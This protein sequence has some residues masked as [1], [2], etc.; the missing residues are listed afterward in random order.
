MHRL[1]EITIRHPKR[2]LAL[3]LV[4]AAAMAAFAFAVG[5][6]LSPSKTVISGTESARAQQLAEDEF[7]PS[8]LVPILLRGPAA[9]VDRQG[10]QLVRALRARSD[11]RVLSA[12]DPQQRESLRPSPGAAMVV[13]SVARSEE[14]MVRTVQAQ[15]ERTVDNTVSG[16][17]S[18]A[19]TGQPSIDRALKNAALDA[20]VRGSLLAL[21]I[22]LLLL[23]V[24]L[25]RPVAALVVTTFAAIAALTGIGLVALLARLIDTDPIAVAAG[26]LTGL[27]LAA[28]Y[29]MTM[30]QRFCA[31]DSAG[32][33]RSRTQSAALAAAIVRL[34]GRGV[35]VGGSA[36]VVALAVA[37]RIAPPAALTSL[38]IGAVV[39]AAVSMLLSVTALPAVLVLLGRRLDALAFA[40]PRSARVS[41]DQRLVTRHAGVAGFVATLALAALAIPVLSMQTG[42]PDI[43]QLPADSTARK[44]FE[45]VGTVMGPGWATPFAITLADRRRPITTRA[46]LTRIGGLQKQIAGDPRVAS[47]A[48]PGAF[49]AQTSDLEKLPEALEDSKKLLTGG[50]Q[51]LA[52][53]EAGLGRAGEGAIQLRSGLAGASTGA[54][55]LSGGGRDAVAGAARL[56][57]GLADA[58]AGSRKISSGLASALGGAVALRTGA[59]RALDGATQIRTGLGAA[60]APVTKSVPQAEALAGAVGS[61]GTAVGTASRS[62][63]EATASLERT[64]SGL[65]AMDVGKTDPSYAATLAAAQAARASVGATR[66]AL[67]AASGTLSV[68]GAGT[69]ALAAQVGV[70]STALTALH[71]GATQLQAGIAQ[72]RTGNADLAAGIAQ[73][74]TGGKSLTAGLGQLTSGAGSLENGLGQL[75]SGAASLAVGLQGA[76]GPTGELANGLDT[77]R[78]GVTTFSGNLPSPND[79]EE[80]QRSS[81]GLFDSGYFVLAAIAGAPAADRNVAG[82]AVNVDHGGTAGQVVV[83]SKTA[84]STDAT[85]ELSRD[86]QRMAAAFARDNRLT[87]AV[88]GPG[89]N[90]SDYRAETASRIAPA[91]A[92]VALA[93]ALL[94]MLMLRSILIPLVAAGSAL[95]ASAAT[96]G[97]LRLLFVGEDPLLGGPGYIDPMAIIAVFSAAF[98]LSAVFAGILLD[99]VRQ[100]FV[101]C[102]DIGE[103]VAT[104]LRSS[105]RAGVAAGLAVALV[106]VPF[107]LQDVLN[108]RQ[109][110]VG[111][112]IMAIIDVLLMRSLQLPAAIEVLRAPAWWPTVGQERPRRRLGP[113]GRAVV[114]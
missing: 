34:S 87:A 106:A 95:L 25:R 90:V 107:A 94:L 13:A 76:V 22:L 49:V 54:S 2:T 112:G 56:H 111:L 14:D 60:A 53:L 100:Q 9:Q 29:G 37:S 8:V 30:T 43:T 88:G 52:E 47:V 67:A 98:G 93:V 19:V 6:R 84:A 55:Q 28:V 82:F 24:V 108:L 109:L 20:A 11:T 73:L 65:D 85:Y 38:G 36:F 86:L 89:A 57:A 92:G 3:T 16:P 69:K 59:R 26:A 58:R 99:E 103:A 5:D 10:R 33:P 96:F 63:G 1:A 71:G 21:P 45:T 114:R 18:A 68:A 79:L 46:V 64:L 80:L 7:G 4:F 51:D 42:P 50:K 104:A 75:S 97:M 77:M 44:S 41:A 74:N 48:G 17:V 101:A 62:A 32:I 35:L 40:P 61:A 15:I 72:L 91:V 27:G 102:G 110:A 81:P 12:W 78:S 113:R 23:V 70:L 105:A 66:A 39:C 31:H 83:I